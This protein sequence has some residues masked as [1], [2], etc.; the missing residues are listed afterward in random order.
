MQTNMNPP[1]S[2]SQSL[3]YGMSRVWQLVVPTHKGLFGYPLLL[4]PDLH[5]QVLK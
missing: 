4:E 1:L 3:R 5:V 2:P